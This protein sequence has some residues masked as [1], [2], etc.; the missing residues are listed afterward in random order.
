VVDAH[1]AGLARGLVQLEL[2]RGRQAF[3]HLVAPNDGAGMGL[4]P[5]E[6]VLKVAL[7]LT[8]LA[9]EGDA[10][11]VEMVVV[12]ADDV[13][14]SASHGERMPQAVFIAGASVSVA[15]GARSRR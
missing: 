14:W 12:V 8:P 11:T 1:E 5:T 2:A 7:V 4:A 13:A 15:G 9:L 3:E 10:P 6:D